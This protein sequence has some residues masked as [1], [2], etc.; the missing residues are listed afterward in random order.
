LPLLIQRFLDKTSDLQTCAYISAYACTSLHVNSSTAD[1]RDGN[2]TNNKKGIAKEFDPDL[3]PF[4]KFLQ[5]YRDFLNQLMMWNV[6][7]DFDVAHG[8]LKTNFI[9]F[10]ETLN[11]F[12]KN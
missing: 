4:K 3:V 2:G 12:K 11:S 7:A 1:S 5:C 8:Q 6:R 9:I 10:R